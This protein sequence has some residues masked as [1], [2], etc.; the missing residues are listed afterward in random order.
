[1]RIEARLI[2]ANTEI[3]AVA[4]EAGTEP[5]P[6]LKNLGKQTTVAVCLGRDGERATVKPVTVIQRWLLTRP[7]LGLERGRWGEVQERVCSLKRPRGY[8]M[9][10]NGQPRLPSYPMSSRKLCYSL[11]TFQPMLTARAQ[12]LWTFTVRH[13]E[14]FWA[15]ECGP[16]SY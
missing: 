3:P 13:S 9:L 10:T 8:S 6:K 11:D 14:T 12:C 2:L 1:M 16:H 7:Q 15:H 5:L 4:A